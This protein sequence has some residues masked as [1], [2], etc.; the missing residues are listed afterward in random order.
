MVK[1]YHARIFGG[2]NADWR[3][4]D[5]SKGHFYPGALEMALN[6]TFSENIFKVREGQ[7]KEA[8][9]GQ[10]SVLTGVNTGAYVLVMQGEEIFAEAL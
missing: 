6:A 5:Q 1:T 9:L 7:E 2:K 8:A 10:G 4:I 3:G